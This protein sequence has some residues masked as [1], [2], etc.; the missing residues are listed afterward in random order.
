MPVTNTGKFRWASACGICEVKVSVLG[1]GLNQYPPPGAWSA[2][3]WAVKGNGCVVSALDKEQD[4]NNAD[5]ASKDFIPASFIVL[6][7]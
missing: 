7:L 3:V 4:K 5:Q 6:F 1:V 2:G